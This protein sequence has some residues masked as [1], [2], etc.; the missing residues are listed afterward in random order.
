MFNLFISH[1]PSRVLCLFNLLFWLLLNTLAADWNYRQQIA[2]GREANFFETWIYHIPWWGNWALVTPFVIA[3]IRTITIED[4]SRVKFIALNLLVMVVTMFVYWSLTVIEITLIDNNWGLNSNGLVGSFTDLLNSPLHL[5]FVM[6]LAVA[7][8]GLNVSFYNKARDQVNNNQKLAN[9]LLD[10]ELQSLKSQLSPH[11]LFNTLNTIS[12]LIRLDEKNK[13]VKA[14][15][16]LSQMFRKV[17][18]NQKTQ[19]TTLRNEMKFVNSYLAIQKM[20]FETKLRV[21]MEISQESLDIEVPFMLLHTLV[22]N[23]VQHGSQMESD[24]NLIKLWVTTDGKRLYINLINKVTQQEHHHGFGI[25]FDNCQKR[26][27]R[28][29]Q[30]NYTLVCKETDDGHYKTE[31]TIPIGEYA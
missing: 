25:G 19:L 17:L 16:D 14:L 8:L 18:E 7:S 5:D 24:H 29:Y 3:W 22:E 10:V 1:F 28:L 11:F 23:A 9:Q 13:A 31:L 20:R 12:G 6:Y 4:Q 26:L 30:E 27:S 2:Y 21:Q 15:S